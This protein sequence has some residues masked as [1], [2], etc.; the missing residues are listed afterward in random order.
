MPARRSGERGLAIQ[1]QLAFLG[2]C[3]FGQRVVFLLKPD[4]LGFEVPYT[5]LKAA[6]LGNDTRIWTADVAE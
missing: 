1:N 2:S 6:H 5:L 3:L 4:K